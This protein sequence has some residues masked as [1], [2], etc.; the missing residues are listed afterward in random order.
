MDKRVGKPYRS[1]GIKLK[2][3]REG[4]KQTIP[5][6]SGAVEIEAKVLEQI[7]QGEQRPAEDIL[8]LLISYFGVKE[9]EASKLWELAGYN[10]LSNDSQSFDLGQQVAMVMPMDLRVVYTDMVHVMVNDFG[11]I[12][13]FMQGNG[14]KN[15]PLAVARIGMSHEHARS[16]MDVLGK[17]LHQAQQKSAPKQLGSGKTE[18]GKTSKSDKEAKN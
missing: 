5:E 8:A 4:K 14:P 15:Q 9:D 13:N 17:S 11:V 3:F 16:V 12:M 2:A 1:L 10:E 6:V 18:S 7:E